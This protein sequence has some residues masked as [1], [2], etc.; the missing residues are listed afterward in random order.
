MR[1]NPAALS[2]W[3]STPTLKA[4]SSTSTISHWCWGC[5]PYAWRGFP[6]SVWAL[7]EILK[8]TRSSILSRGPGMW[9][10]QW[11]LSF[12]SGGFDETGKFV[13]IPFGNLNRMSEYFRRVIIKLFLKKKLI[14]R[15]LPRRVT[16]SLVD[17]RQGRSG[18]SLRGATELALFSLIINK[19]H[20]IFKL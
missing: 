13:H 7:G 19:Y 6:K 14:L 18:S 12:R 3:P 9:P 2:E 15:S 20:V 11:L 17:A 8:P 4:S 5:A 1:T 16:P 10:L